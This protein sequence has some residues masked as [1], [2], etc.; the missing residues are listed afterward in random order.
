MFKKNLTLITLFAL[1][2]CGNKQEEV[3]SSNG[4]PIHIVN[5][6]DSKMFADAHIKG[7]KN[8]SLQDI[9]TTAKNWGKNDTIVIYCSNYMCT[10]S[11][12]A[13]EK[14]IEQGFTDVRVYEGGTAEW[15]QL[16][17]QDSSYALVGPAKERYLEIVLE[18]PTTH[19][20]K[21]KEISALEL[22]KLLKDANILS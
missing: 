7:S 3:R 6:L 10:A 1:V 15:Y 16:S 22:K 2:G 11:A 14:L 20:E 9:G 4:T 19:Q 8:I 17:K 12:T 13:A 5:V 18:K 21:V